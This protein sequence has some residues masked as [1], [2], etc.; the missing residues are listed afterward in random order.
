MTSPSSLPPDDLP[1]IILMYS[2]NR[3]Y[4]LKVQGDGKICVYDFNSYPRGHA[5]W[6]ST[7][8]QTPTH[9]PYT[10]E[11][12][13]DGNLSLMG[14]KTVLLWN[15][16]VR[17]NLTGPYTL[18]IPNDG[19]LI[20]TRAGGDVVW[21][22]HTS[23]P[24]PTP[25]YITSPSLDL[26]DVFLL[27]SPNNMFAIKMGTNGLLCL[28]NFSVNPYGGTY[29]CAPNNQY[30]HDGIITAP[31]T[32]DFN[33]DGNIALMGQ[34]GNISVW[35]N[36]VH[37]DDP[38]YT[39]RVLNNG[40]L[41]ETSATGNIVWQITV[42]QNATS[43]TSPDGGDPPV[44]V[45]AGIVVGSLVAASLLIGVTIV[46]QRVWRRKRSSGMNNP[47]SS[48]SMEL[49]EVGGYCPPLPED[50]G[51][52]V[53]ALDVRPDALF[54]APHPPPSSSSIPRPPPSSV[55]APRKILSYD[56]I[57]ILGPLGEGTSGIVHKAVWRDTIVAVKE[58]KTASLI[59]IFFML[60]YIII[61][62]GF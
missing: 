49:L 43:P 52:A 14:N 16:T 41:V 39:L 19:K 11:L 8:D 27:F 46:A 28:Y 29:W 22:S 57:K 62:T 55:N 37:D 35:D 42:Y 24:E 20:E 51:H 53:L 21:R 25:H 45:N 4:A 17:N 1:S 36:K 12:S 59:F 5:D 2:R 15:N 33:F 34:N 23:T 13:S 31:F 54:S 3:R 6:C 7:V 26:P 10:L 60:F 9:R 48:A 38:P 50:D 30:Y 18:I 32:L 44:A 61:W 40:S 47:T 56:D 58:L